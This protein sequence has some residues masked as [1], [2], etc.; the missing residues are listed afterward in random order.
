MSFDPPDLATLRAYVAGTLA[1]DETEA[2]RTWLIVAATEDVLEIVDALALAAEQARVRESYWVTHPLRA[3]LARLAWHARSTIRHLFELD[4]GDSASLASMLGSESERLVLPSQGGTIAV[5]PGIAV[6]LLVTPASRV[7][8]GAY[9][10]D[11]DGRLLVLSAAPSVHLPGTTFELGA[12]A[13]DAG[14]TLDVFVVFDN[15]GPLPAPPEGADASWL[16]DVLTPVS[17]SRAVIS[18]ALVAE[19]A[20]PGGKQR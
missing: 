5:R 7:W 1:P 8:C 15:E 2:I 11:G 6:D 18:T 3:R 10:V 9:A 16:A 20:G 4:L 17:K 13:L 19:S 14:E 12:V